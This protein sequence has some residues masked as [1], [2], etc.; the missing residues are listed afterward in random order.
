[1]GV[2][3]AYTPD[4][5]CVSLL[6][7]LLTNFCVYDCAYCVNRV[8]SNIDAG[9][10]LGRGG[11]RPHPRFLQ[12]QLHRGPVPLLGRD[13]SADYTQELLNRVARTLR[14]DARLPRLHPSQADRR[15]LARSWRP[16]PGSTP[17]GCR[18]ISSCRWR[19]AWTRLAPEKIGRRDQAGDGSGALRHRGRRRPQPDRQ[20]PA[21]LRPGRPVDPDDRRRRRGHRRRRAGAVREPLRRLWPAPGLLFRLQPDP[22][23]Q[24]EPAAR[25][26]RT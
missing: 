10:V 26:R 9:A 2:C 3:H 12:A 19:P 17:T 25:S 7:I 15:L 21:P 24:R 11:G 18:S 4:G 13:P 22:G 5:R 20:A 14:E 16:R 23:F 1:M 8:S 6:K